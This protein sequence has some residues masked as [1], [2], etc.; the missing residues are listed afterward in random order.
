MRLVLFIF[1]WTVLLGCGDGQLALL[2]EDEQAT[3]NTEQAEDDTRAEDPES[4]PAFTLPREYAQLLPYHVRMRKLATLTGLPLDD[5]A[6]EDLRRNRYALGDHNFGQGIGAD[7][8][9][10]AAKMS[11]W[12][13]SLKLVCASDAIKSRYPALPEDIN[14]F[15]LAAYGREVD[16]TDLELVDAA[17]GSTSDPAQRYE[18]ICLAMLS[19]MEFV[20][21]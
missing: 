20:G 11:T 16:Q 15:A 19:S 8:T 4:P 1:A 3:F 5:A 2:V 6:F 10:S 21:R 13:K 7:L 12:V 9:W 18:A 17:I 14:E